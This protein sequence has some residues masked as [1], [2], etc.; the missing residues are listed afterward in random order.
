MK[1]TTTTIDITGC[2]IIPLDE[3]EQLK[4]DAASLNVNDIKGLLIEMRRGDTD[5]ASYNDIL[6][7]RMP[8]DRKVYRYYRYFVEVTDL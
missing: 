6:I 4:R 3:Y 2:A 7:K 5:T 8:D 1:H